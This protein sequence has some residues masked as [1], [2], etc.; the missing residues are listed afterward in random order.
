MTNMGKS[1]K[2]IEGAIRFSLSDELTENDI[3]EC[4]EILIK[5]VATIRK[6]VR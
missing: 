5:E 3:D 4:V 1:K 2:E 6:Y